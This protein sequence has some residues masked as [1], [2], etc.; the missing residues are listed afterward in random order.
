MAIQLLL[1]VAFVLAP[2]WN[3]W[4]SQRLFVASEVPRLA[5]LIAGG[6]AAVGL[7]GLGL[8]EIRRYLTPLPFPVDHNR[9]VTTGVYR[10]VR[11]PLYSSQLAAA[12]GW[13][14][15]SLSLSHLAILVLAFLF[16][17]YKAGKEEVWLAGRHP[18]YKAY[19]QRVRRLI[20]WIY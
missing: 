5:A 2:Q 18:G 17:D 9:L 19:A 15:F 13:T 3:P 11:H 20:P 12:L 4:A 7:G 14:L 16:F 8:L 10:L 6:A 1:F